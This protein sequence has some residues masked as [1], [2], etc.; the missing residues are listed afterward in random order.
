MVYDHVELNVCR[1]FVP[2]GAN[3]IKSVSG[4]GVY[5]AGNASRPANV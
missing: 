4:R 1:A 3:K 5:V 2:A